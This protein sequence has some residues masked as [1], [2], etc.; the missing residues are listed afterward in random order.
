MG[1]WTVSIVW[2]FKYQK[3]KILKGPK[4]I[5]V[6]LSSFEDRNR[7]SFGKVVYSV[8]YNFGRWTK[9]INPVILSVIHHCQ[10]PLS[11]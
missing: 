8:I 1:L 11:S 10:K 9:C 3:T 2:N 6:F 5:G 7:S 4:K